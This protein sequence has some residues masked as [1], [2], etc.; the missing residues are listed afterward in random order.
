MGRR[1]VL[2]LT[3]VL[4]LASAAC[5]VNFSPKNADDSHTDLQTEPLVLLLAPVNGSTY[6]EGTRVELLAIAQD[7]QAGVSRID[8]LVDSAPVDEVPASE[9]SGQPSLEAQVT[10]TATGIQGHLITVEA[11]R[12]DGSSLGRSEVLVRVAGK[13]SANGAAAGTS[14]PT[15]EPNPGAATPVPTPTSAPTA[16]PDDMGI[17]SGP[18]A[19]IN[20]SSLNVRQGPGTNYAPV[21]TLVQGDQVQIVGRNADSSWWAIQYGNGTGWVIASLVIPEGDMSQVPL[22]AAP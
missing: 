9:P 6:A 4:F 18:L 8:F 20:T 10:W 13:P 7:T 5:S 14:A 19:R 12:A 15:I 22:V 11:F 16:R 1:T 2:F 21:G 17:L 3:I